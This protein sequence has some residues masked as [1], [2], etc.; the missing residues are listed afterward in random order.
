MTPVEAAIVRA[1]QEE[2]ID[3]ATALAWA[4]RESSF[5]PTARASKSIYGLFQMSG[6]LRRQYGIGDT[7]D[8]YEQTKGFA[9]YYRGLKSEMAKTLGRDPTDTEAYLGHH[10]GGVRGARTLGMNP[11]TPVSA[12][13][14]PY[15]RS[16]NPHFDRAG[17]IGNLTGSIKSDID[18][19]YAKFGGQPQTSGE[20]LDFTSQ[21]QNDA[22]G[23]DA[24][25][26]R[27]KK[28]AK[29]GNYRTD[30][31]GKEANF[32]KWV[33]DN[34]VPFDPD[35]TGPDDYDMR[36]F[37]AA[38]QAGDKRASTAPNP[39]DGKMHYD[40]FWKTP[41][42]KSFSSES[43]WAQPNAPRWNAKDQ[44]IDPSNGGVVFDERA[45]SQKPYRTEPLDFSQQVADAGSGIMDRISQTG[46]D[47]AGAVT[48][49]VTPKS[50]LNPPPVTT[51]AATMGI[52]GE[53]EPLDFTTQVQQG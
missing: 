48:Q 41:Y 1:A 11:N 32:R 37:W 43:Q 21:V 16:L 26:E 31:G 53:G 46:R 35:K 28:W 3:P 49:A 17:S 19:R 9:R 5:S 38:A 25:Y 8:P 40:D 29:P 12:V 39:N 23:P 44:L 47:V 18:R 14:T 4:S 27:N 22:D 20:L 50:E 10:F 33:A 15:E 7:S 36:G 24:L 6:A 45:G 52:R 30:L 13:F 34:K 51:P 42:H 2:G